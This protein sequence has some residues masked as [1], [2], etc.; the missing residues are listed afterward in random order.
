V[1][2]IT[3]LSGK[4][5]SQISVV[6]ILLLIIAGNILLF[7]ITLPKDDKRREIIMGIKYLSGLVL[8][9]L[10]FALLGFLALGLIL[11]V[12]TVVVTFILLIRSISEGSIA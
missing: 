7:R 4:Q 5:I 1:T 12:V 9:D 6:S 10:I 2:D 11:L 8:I 3:E